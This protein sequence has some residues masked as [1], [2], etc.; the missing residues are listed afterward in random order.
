M[1]PSRTAADA[2]VELGLREPGRG[3]QVVEGDP[4]EPAH[5]PLERMQH[6]E[7]IGLQG[8]YHLGRE[9]HLLHHWHADG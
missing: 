8:P 7:V 3:L 5:Q 2:V 6:P 1:Q 4:F 9:G